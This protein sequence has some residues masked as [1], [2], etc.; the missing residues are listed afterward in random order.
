MIPIEISRII[1]GS[2]NRLKTGSY[3]LYPNYNRDRN[4]DSSQISNFIPD[5]ISSRSASLS[6]SGIVP[7]NSFGVGGVNNYPIQD[8]YL[9]PWSHAA[10]LFS[11]VVSILSIN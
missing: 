10:L 3:L 9:W 5:V 7:R 6:N 11:L 2:L 4:V 8:K 1:Q